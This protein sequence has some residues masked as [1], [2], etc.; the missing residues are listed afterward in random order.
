MINPMDLTGKHII[1]TGASSGIG[2]AA[3][4]Q[5]S[6]LGAHVTL[7]ARNEEK[8]NETVSLMSGDMHNIVPADLTEIDKIDGLIAD[9]SERFGAIDGLVHCAGLGLNRP[10]KLAKPEFVEQVTRLNYFAFVELIR[11]AASRKRSNNG[12]SYIG[13]SSV[14]A[15]HGNKTQGVYSASKG[16]MNSIV[17]SFAKELAARE[18]RVNTIAFGMVDTDMYKG[19]LESG[20]NNEELLQDQYLGIIPP[21]YAGNAICFL[22]SDAGKYITGS[23][24]NYDA[25][26]LS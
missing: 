10:I 15:V 18:I 22:L 8:L 2:R 20:G 6:K 12:A 7:I 26:D 14:A 5:A 13:I 23:T 19:F 25:G 24:F 1:I 11:A 3:S 17:H 4:I 16:A 9:I 21:E